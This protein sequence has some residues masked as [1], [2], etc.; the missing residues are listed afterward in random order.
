MKTRSVA[1]D[2]VLP[3]ATL[4]LLG[5][6]VALPLWGPGLLN[7]RS[8]G[9]SPFLIMRTHQL[10]AALRGGHFPARWMPDAAYGLGFPMFS[11]YAALPYYLAATLHLVQ[12]DILS[13]IKLTQT[14][15]AIAAALATYGWARRLFSSRAVGW[16]AGAAYAVAPYHLVNLYVRGDALSEFAAFAF[17]PLILWGLD[18]LLQ[19]P[20]PRRVLFPAL[21]YAGLSLTHNISALTFTPFALLYYG[22]GVIRQA[23][24]SRLRR[25]LAG[26]G[27]WA[28]GLGRAAETLTKKIYCK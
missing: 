23:G 5:L 8:G 3:P 19:E 11:Y 21:A 15:F 27:A 6:V 22:V 2:R 20:V 14:L 24:G 13:S 7:T 16:L 4:F 10:A 28:L 17:Y 18:R 12:L 9:D 25:T 1:W 26:L